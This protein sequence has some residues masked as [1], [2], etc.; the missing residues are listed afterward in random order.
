MALCLKGWQA[1]LVPDPT[2]YIRKIMKDNRILQ[3]QLDK[4]FVNTNGTDF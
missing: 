1:S 2:A 3:A 4:K